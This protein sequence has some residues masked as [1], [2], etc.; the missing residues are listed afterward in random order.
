MLGVGILLTVGTGFFV[1]SEFALVN[2]DRSDLEVR[3]T[4]GERGLGPVIGALKMTSTHLSSAQLGI[5]LTTLL[6]GYTL[7]A[8]AISEKDLLPVDQAFAL[9]AEATARDRIELRW[10][11]APGYYLY[12][13][14][15]SAKAGPGFT[16]GA[17]LAVPRRLQGQVAG[18]TASING[19]AYIIAPA[20]GVALYNWHA[21]LTFLLI[22]AA[23]LLL[24]LWGWRG[25]RDAAP[26]ITIR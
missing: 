5:T 15:T 6:A 11:I 19:A 25:L 17:S 23:G 10:D 8:W 20:V 2:L 22:A 9:R 7:P 1:A 24:A 21:M 16:A 4:R 14:R 3:Q 12:R 18:Q 13:H 26:V